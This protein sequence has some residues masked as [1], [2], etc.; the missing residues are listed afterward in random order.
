MPDHT[1]IKLL[2]KSIL[3]NPTPQTRN[4]SLQG[5][6]FLRS[7]LSSELRLHV[8]DS[9]Y[10]VKNVSGIHTHP[11]DFDSYIVAGELHQFRYKEVG[12]NRRDIEEFDATAPDAYFRSVIKA[13]PGGGLREAPTGVYLMRGDEEGYGE[14]GS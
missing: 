10:R 12:I 14:E 5:F 2:V 8:W 13:G 4:W 9:R 7:Y 1:A 6:G 11:W 3:E